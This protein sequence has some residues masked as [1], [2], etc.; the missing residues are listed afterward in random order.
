MARCLETDIEATSVGADVAAHPHN[1]T[2]NFTGGVDGRGPSSEAKARRNGSGSTTTTVAAPAMR[3]SS[4]ITTRR[5]AAGDQDTL[6][7]KRF[8]VSLHCVH[9]DTGRFQKRGVIEGKGLRA[10]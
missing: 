4:A 9:G 2:G 5:A 3:A 7:Q 10:A 6:G 1:F 8:A